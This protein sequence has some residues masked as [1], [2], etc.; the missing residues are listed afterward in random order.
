MMDN[1]FTFVSWLCDEWRLI[2]AER[3]D[4]LR[5]AGHHVRSGVSW[6]TAFNRA[7]E[8]HFITWGQL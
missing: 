1:A 3:A 4:V 8:E 5:R 6:T 2:G 7:L